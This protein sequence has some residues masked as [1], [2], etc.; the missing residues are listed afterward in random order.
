VTLTLEVL[1]ALRAV[2][3]IGKRVNQ[4]LGEGVKKKDDPYQSMYQ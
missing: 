1:K 4:V 3:S 2:T